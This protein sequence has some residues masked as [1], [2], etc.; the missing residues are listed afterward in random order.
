MAEGM[1]IGDVVRNDLVRYEENS[2]MHFRALDEMNVREFAPPR[3]GVYCLAHSDAHDEQRVERPY[4]F[5]VADDL[6]AA[7]AR[8]LQESDPELARH[9]E[10]GDRWFRVV[11]AEVAQL[12]AAVADLKSKYD[13]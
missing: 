1:M 3:P 11:L 6:Y 2:V 9:E 5:A 4:Y 8:H 7:L 12:D 10:R 13:G